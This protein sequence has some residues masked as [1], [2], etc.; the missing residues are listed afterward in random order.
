M[1]HYGIPDEAVGTIGVVGPTRMHYARTISA[2]GF[3]SSMMSKLI[4]D[5][6]GKEPR[7]SRGKMQNN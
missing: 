5:L 4:S 6:Y 2:I 7:N 3:M 1:S